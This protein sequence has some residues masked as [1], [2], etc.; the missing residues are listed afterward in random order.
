MRNEG[1]SG[2]KFDQLSF[3]LFS[4][5]EV[6]SKPSIVTAGLAISD[7]NVFLQLL[8]V[9]EAA[10]PGAAVGDEPGDGLRLVGRHVDAAHR[11]V[12]TH[13]LVV[14]LRKLR[15]MKHSRNLDQ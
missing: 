12:P 10:V 8:G 1:S 9:G 14:V 15:F 2:F 13:V 6:I 11:R 3:P 7:L 4:Q 5:C